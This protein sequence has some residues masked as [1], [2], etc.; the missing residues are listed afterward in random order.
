MRPAL[1]WKRV[2]SGGS[3]RTFFRFRRTS[4]SDCS[5]AVRIWLSFSPS[6]Q[7]EIREKLFIIRS[8]YAL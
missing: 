8:P 6:A 2:K 3:S 1:E 5:S 7:F 4:V